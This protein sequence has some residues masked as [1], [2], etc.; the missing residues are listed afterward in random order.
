M[1]EIHSPDISAYS[2]KGMKAGNVFVKI[3]DRHQEVICR[4]TYESIYAF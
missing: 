2:Y 3:A 4:Y 1:A